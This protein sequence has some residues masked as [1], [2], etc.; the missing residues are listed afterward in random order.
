MAA[1][2]SRR[3][4]GPTQVGI[5]ATLQILLEY[6]KYASLGTL[7]S[8]AREIPYLIGKGETRTA[9]QIKNVVF[10]V[11]LSGSFLIGWVIFLFAFLTRGRF[12]PEMTYG[13]FFVSGMIVLQRVGDLLIG[14]LRCY[15]KFGL[16]SAQMIWSSIV[17]AVLV[18]VLTYFFKIYGFIWAIAL[19]YIF[20]ILYI[21]LHHD[22]HLKFNFEP[23]RFQS[24]VLF[25]LPLMLIGMLTTVVRSVD[26]ILVA[27]FLGFEALGFYSIALMVSSF[28]GNFSNSI[29]IVLVPHLQ[30]RFGTQDNPKDLSGFL[31]KTGEAFS[32][33]TPAVIGAAWLLGPFLIR[34]FLPQFVPGIPAMKILS[35]S[36]FFIALTQPYSDF[37][38]TIKKHYALFPLLGT[39]SIAALLFN[40]M[41]IRWAYGVT[42]VAFAT[43]LVSFFN[44]TLTY[45]YAAR[46]LDSV[47]SAF[48]SFGLY[49]GRALYLVA[50]LLLIDYLIPGKVVVFERTLAQFLLFIACYV[51]LWIAL[52]R[53]FGLAGLLRKRIVDFLSSFSLLKSVSQK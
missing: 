49:L 12:A 37:L 46:F 39:T 16:A 38:I 13:L 17:N 44:F 21:Q 1:V 22:F 2:L 15:K 29:G 4:L 41:A 18:G 35:L 10:T 42:G 19:S 51:P 36:L 47:S 26:R 20:N 7:Y 5:W 45:F 43:A 8:V 24:I 48:Q 25:G 40:T 28:I 3:F 27:K 9:E 30:E 32:L 53:Q 33:I 14:L 11:V 31:R 50:A 52:N 6:S 23:K 34:L